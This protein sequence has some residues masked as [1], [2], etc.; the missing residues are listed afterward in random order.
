MN[1]DVGNM[2]KRYLSTPNHDHNSLNYLK[3]KEE[4]KG[5]SYPY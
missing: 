3:I 1:V 2:I 4:K 5:K